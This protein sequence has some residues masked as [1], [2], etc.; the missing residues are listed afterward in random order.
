MFLKKIN[1]KNNGYIYGIYNMI[2]LIYYFR[3]HYFL[4]EFLNQ[5]PFEMKILKMAHLTFFLF[6]HLKMIFLHI[7]QLLYIALKK[8]IH[9]LIIIKLFTWLT[10]Y[11]NHMESWCLI[12]TTNFIKIKN[13]FNDILNIFSFFSMLRHFLCKYNLTSHHMKLKI[14]IFFSIWHLW[15]LT[16]HN[17]QKHCESFS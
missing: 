1:L 7:L 13:H 10:K 15:V 4:F 17:M 12:D 3:L 16:Y 8:F 5:E 11:S 14:Y 9:N 6:L 2:Y